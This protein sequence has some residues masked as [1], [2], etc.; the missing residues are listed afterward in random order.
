M[1]KE[2]MRAVVVDAY[3]WRSADIHAAACRLGLREDKSGDAEELL[4]DRLRM[5]RYTLDTLKSQ[6]GVV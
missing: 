1:K 6:Y 5:L 2:L 3:L 4:E